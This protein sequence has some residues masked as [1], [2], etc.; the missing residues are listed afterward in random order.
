M[1]DIVFKSL[2]FKFHPIWPTTAGVIGQKPF[3]LILGIL[4]L[5]LPYLSS[6]LK[7]KNNSYVKLKQNIW[8]FNER[9]KN[10]DR[11]SF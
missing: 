3:L 2:S 8:A 10:L 6:R 4:K 11:V 9:K 1:K 7:Y 5:V